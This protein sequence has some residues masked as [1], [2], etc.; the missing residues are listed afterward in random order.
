VSAFVV[1]N[2]FFVGAAQEERT[3]GAE[4]DLFQRVEK[5]LWSDVLLLSAGGQ[6]RRFIDQVSQIRSRETRSRGGYLL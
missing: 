6:Q 2:P 5:V 4:N 3:L 1:R